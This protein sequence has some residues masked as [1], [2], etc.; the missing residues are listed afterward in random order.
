VVAD[1]ELFKR[2]AQMKPHGARPGGLPVALSLDGPIGSNTTLLGISLSM[3][4][5]LGVLPPPRA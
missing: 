1:P 3:N 5:V 2:I 4:A